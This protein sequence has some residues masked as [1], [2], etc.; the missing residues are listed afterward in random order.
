MKTER[1]IGNRKG[2]STMLDGISKRA[3]RLARPL[4]DRPATASHYG[5]ELDGSILIRQSRNEDKAA[6]ERLAALDS[7]TLPAGSFL[8]AEV[9]GELLAAAALEYDTES[10]SDPFRPTRNLRELLA[11][12]ARHIQT[13]RGGLAQLALAHPTPKKQRKTTSRNDRVDPSLR[14]EGGIP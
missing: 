7:R 9:D 1:Q 5:L 13:A 10:L 4:R 3:T 12:Q 8:L 14:A 11:L 6:L 2:G